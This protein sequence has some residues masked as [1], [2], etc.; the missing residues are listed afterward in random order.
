MTYFGFLALFLAPPLLVLGLATQADQRRGIQLP[1]WLNAW[2]LSRVILLHVLLALIYTTP[3]DNYLVATNVWWYNPEL[4]T[5]LTFGW[6][7][8]EEYTFFILQT[9]MTG[10][11]L[12]FL[13]RRMYTRQ[14]PPSDLPERFARHM[15]RVA[16]LFLLPVWVGALYSLIIGWQSST[17]LALILVWAL[18]PLMLQLYFGADILWKY[19][20][21]VASVLISTT[22]YL[23]L[24][25]ALA[26]QAGTWVINPQQTLNILLGGVLPIE[27][28]VF[29]FVT[30]LLIVFGSVLILARESQQRIP[31]YLVKRLYSAARPTYNSNTARQI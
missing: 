6:V 26:I 28:F 21:L 20:K 9:L 29:F 12:G 4:V 23:A 22:L 15:R 13:A 3:W 17:Y 16:S 10:L 19:R 31:P 27:E 1:G 8:I 24:A 5:G 11:W 7:P 2:P 25:D 30:N 18:P 14:S